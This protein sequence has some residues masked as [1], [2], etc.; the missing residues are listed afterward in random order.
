MKYKRILALAVALCL[1]LSILPGAA[2]ETT[3]GTIGESHV[4]WSFDEASGRL[5]I[6]GSG[7]CEVFE[8]A[9][10]QPWA[11][12]RDEIRAAANRLVIP[13]QA[14]YLPAKGLEQLLKTVAKVKRNINPQLQIEGILLTMVDS[15]TNFAREISQLIRDT[16]GGKIRVFD[17]AIPYSVRAKECSAVGKSVYAHDPKGKVAEAYHNLTKEVLQRE[18]QREANKAGFC[19]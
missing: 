19:R 4:S 16:Y 2:W 11:A 6:S 5:T 12:L 10:D 9:E 14:E 1:C 7:G 17:T 13:V 15:R 18:K 3:S 8:S